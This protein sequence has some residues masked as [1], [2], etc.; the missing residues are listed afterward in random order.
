MWGLEKLE[1]LRLPYD[2]LDCLSTNIEADSTCGNMSWPASL[3]DILMGGAF[4]ES[5]LSTISWPPNLTSLELE[6]CEDLSVDTLG[7]LL[8]TP[9][10]GRTLKSFTI[11]ERND[12]LTP[13]S[14]NIIPALLPALEYLSVPGDLVKDSFFEKL[15]YMTTSWGLRTL[16]LGDNYEALDL[17]FSTHWL[18]RALNG[19]LAKLRSVEFTSEFLDEMQIRDNKEIHAVLLKRAGFKN[20]GRFPVGVSYC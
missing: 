19:G 17:D 9:H 14:I 2:S 1:T 15:A 4:S 10:L 11:T 20:N 18:L 12:M 6:N 13:E 3:H 16:A 5:I 8:S 7:A